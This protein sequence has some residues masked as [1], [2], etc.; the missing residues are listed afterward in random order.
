M[1]FRN[2]HRLTRDLTIS[3][4]QT[5]IGIDRSWIGVNVY[6]VT[7]LQLLIEWWNKVI[8][9][10]GVNLSKDQRSDDMAHFHAAVWIRINELHPTFRLKFKD[11]TDPDLLRKIAA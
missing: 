9:Y 6:K 5:I 10:A 1:R 11:I 7:D 4:E 3:A 2:D 8:R